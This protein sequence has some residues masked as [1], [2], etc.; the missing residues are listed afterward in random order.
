M[1]IVFID[2]EA[3]KLSADFHRGLVMFHLTV[4]KWGAQRLKAYRQYFDAILRLVKEAGYDVVY[5][6]PFEKDTRAQKLI[7]LF[8]FERVR[9]VRGHVVMQRKLHA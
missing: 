7:G 8:G 5:A 4:R 6:T 2:T 3:G 9:S 1:R